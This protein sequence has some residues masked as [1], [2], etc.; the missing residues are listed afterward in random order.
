MRPADLRGRYKQQKEHLWKKKHL[1]FSILDHKSQIQTQSNF[2][3]PSVMIGVTG[4]YH[5]RAG[6]LYM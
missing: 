5:E 3:M 2:P 1:T 4:A 6:R